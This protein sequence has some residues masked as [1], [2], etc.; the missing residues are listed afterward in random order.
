MQ[1]SNSEYVLKVRKSQ[2]KIV[3]LYLFWFDSEVRKIWSYL[4]PNNINTYT[5][6]CQKLIN[7][8][9]CLFLF[10]VS[11]FILL[12]SIWRLKTAS[13]IVACWWPSLT[14]CHAIL[15]NLDGDQGH[16]SKNGLP[17][18]YFDRTTCF[19]PSQVIS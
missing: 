2:K 12:S 14:C 7:S 18:V 4:Q 5:Y 3:C 16:G 9:K 8:Q 17:W 15:A 19:W 1:L 13:Y 11:M 10:L 6:N